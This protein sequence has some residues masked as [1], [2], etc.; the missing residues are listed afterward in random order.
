MPLP[1]VERT[2][3]AGTEAGKRTYNDF[4]L[5]NIRNMEVS[6]ISQN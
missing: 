2:G 3:T 5:E 4:L 6:F 1:T